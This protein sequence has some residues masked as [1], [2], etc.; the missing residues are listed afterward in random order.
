MAWASRSFSAV[1][2]L[3]LVG[4]CSLSHSQQ[5]PMAK[6]IGIVRVVRGDTPA[7][8]VLVSLEMRGSPIG[9]VYSDARGTIGFYNLPANEYRV[10][11]DDPD[12][13]PFSQTEAV[14]P[15]TSTSY[16]V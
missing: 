7:H 8:P 10:T 9:S 4:L 2:L 1:T 16:F 15:A 13:E 5:S 6:I 3:V 12:Y 11:V 14:N